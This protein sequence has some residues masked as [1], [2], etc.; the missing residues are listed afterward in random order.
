MTFCISNISYKN[1][2][3]YFKSI[4]P[5]KENESRQQYH[6]RC[7]LKYIPDYREKFHK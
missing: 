2:T 4:E 7:T 5:K 1:K 6:M 3:E